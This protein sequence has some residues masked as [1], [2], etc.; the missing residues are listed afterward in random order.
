VRP[1]ALVTGASRRLGLA[2]ARGAAGAGHDVAV[3]FRSDEGAAARA[4]DSLAALGARAEAFR[5]D[6]RDPGS[7][8]RLVGE[9]LGRFGR[10][11]LLVHSASP[12]VSRPVGEVTEADWDDVFGVGPRAAFFLAQAA[13]PA[14]S[15]R[16]GAILL[17][18]DVAATK[19]WPRHVPHSASKA[20][21]DALVRNLAVALAPAVR[22]NGVAPGIVL[23]PEEL[24][25]EEVAR[26]VARTPLARRVSVDDLVAAGLMLAANRSITGQVLAV[27]AG[28]SVA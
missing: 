1:V 4:V 3:H 13:A 22:V 12:W 21:V 26:L 11:D 5:A 28:R 18:S 2:F 6:L 20:A 17:V 19:A 10:L 16:E 7:A 15:E 27:D 24:P 9:A 8:R 23:P 25:A 14:L